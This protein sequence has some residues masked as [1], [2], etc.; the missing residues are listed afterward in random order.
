MTPARAG[1]SLFLLGLVCLV[2]VVLRVERVQLEARTQA[3]LANLIENRRRAWNMQIEMA[4]LRS[5]VQI[6]E[7]IEVMDIEVGAVFD[8]MIVSDAVHQQLASNRR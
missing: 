7:R 2:V 8:E 1:V 4:R 6:C 5:P 3:H